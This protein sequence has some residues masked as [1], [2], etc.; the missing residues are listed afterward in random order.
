MSLRERTADLVAKSITETR[1]RI[2]I[3]RMPQAPHDL[4]RPTWRDAKPTRIARFLDVALAR[5]PGG[6][7]VAGQSADVGRQESIARVINGREVAIWRDGTGRLV[8]GPGACPHL[9]ALLERCPVIDGTLYCRWHGL[10]IAPDGDKLYQPFRAFDDGVL[11]W[12]GLDVPGEP[13]TERPV[14]TPRPSPYASVAAVMTEPGTC[15]PEDVIANRLD[16]WHGAWFHPYAFSDLT[17]DESESDETQLVVD[18]A[19]RLNKTWG[20]PVRARFHCPDK[21][22]IVMTITEGEGA[23]SVVETH[24]TPLGVDDAGQ[25]V[26]MVT[27]AVIA[28]SDRPGFVAARWLAPLLRPSI[29]R[30]AKQLWVDD[31]A[32]AERRYE[33]RVRGEY[34]G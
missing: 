17:V 20:V 21:R 31:L 14:I 19:F 32:Y 13:P 23:T 16:P 28:Y 11:I 27:E 2:P 3:T 1:S 8:A 25:P 12:V 18:V 6:W 9:G 7:F 10:K 26:T 33:L 34:P 22:T 4:M 15:E 24:A 29:I 5:N 30:T